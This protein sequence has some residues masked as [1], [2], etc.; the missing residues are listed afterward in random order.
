M[1]VC[2]MINF[3]IC[4]DKKEF[5]DE[6]VNTIDMVMMKNSEAYETHIFN[7]YNDDFINLIDDKLSWKIYILDIEVKDKSGIDIARKI[8]EKDI[9]S[10]LVFI[11]AYY[12]KYIEDILKSK[13]M[14]L[15]FINKQNDYKK[16]LSST[17]EY[18][19][20]NI[21]KKNIIRFK[22]NGIIYTLGTNDIL[23]ICRD[24]DRKC[25]IKTTSNEFTV[26]KTL[27]E[28]Y[29]LLDDNF[30]YSHRACIV[31]LDRIKVYNKKEH[32][33]IF[34]TEDIIDLVSNRFRMKCK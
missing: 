31:N 33:I 25:T 3:I 32:I 20:K 27:V 21:K 23:Y 5:I 24:K 28:L 29:E 26:S 17:I 22:S 12:D 8:R 6:I 30:V 16:E 4:D 2:C 34:D 13:F 7:E 18:A 9:E 11:T 10:M 1:V 19:L 14:F 15:D